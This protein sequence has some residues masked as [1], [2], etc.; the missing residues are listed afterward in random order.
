MMWGGVALACAAMSIA[1]APQSVEQPMSIEDLKACGVSAI[2]F[3]QR[4]AAAREA[5]GIL[6][7]RREAI[8]IESDAIDAAGRRVRREDRKAFATFTARL[9][10]YTSG[11]AAYHAAVSTQVG[12]IAALDGDRTAFN[13][14]CGYRRVRHADLDVLPPEQRAA[15]VAV[16]KSV[17]APIVAPVDL[18]GL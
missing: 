9:K 6:A 18:A 14:R 3:Q 2:A 8:R 11:A 10:R 4:D 13:L 15:I 1:I 17:D 5:Q 12:R 7:T 16:T